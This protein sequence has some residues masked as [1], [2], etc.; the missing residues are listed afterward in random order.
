MTSAGCDASRA[1]CSV[2]LY[3]RMLRRLTCGRA[4][5]DTYGRREPVNRLLNRAILKPCP[6]EIK[7]L[8]SQDLPPSFGAF[9]RP[10]CAPPRPA[11][12]ACARASMYFS[13]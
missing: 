7:H 12:F 4:L 3:S 2:P 11:A 13:L 9:S 8:I 1:H 6:A 10:A 5:Q